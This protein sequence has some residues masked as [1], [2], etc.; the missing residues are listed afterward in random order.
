VVLDKST[1][2]YSLYL[3]GGDFT[4][5]TLVTEL[6]P[7]STSAFDFRGG[8][9]LS[10]TETLKVYLR[11]GASANHQAPLYFDDI[12]LAAGQNLT[13]PVTPVHVPIIAT[14][15][16]GS[17]TRTTAE[18]SVNDVTSDGN[19]AITERGVVFSTSANPTIADTKVV[20]SGTTGTFNAS[21]TGLVSGTPYHVRAFATNAIGT[22]YGSGITFT[23]NAAPVFSGMTVS[24]QP[25]TS[26]P[27]IESKIL[28]RITDGDG[29]PAA[30]TSVAA[31][32]TEG[33]TLSRSGGIIT[34]TPA[35]A[36]SGP[37]SF[38]VSVDD[39]FG[40]VNVT[41]QVTVAADP[42]FTSPAN[43][44]RLT[45]L[46]GGAKR[47]AFNGIPGRTYAIQRSTTLDPG[48]WTQIAAVTAASDS[49][50]SYEDPTPPQPAAFYRVA[51][52]AQ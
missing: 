22:A 40:A 23:A 24:T 26:V 30:I 25:A 11:S 8:G 1:A 27:I 9:N 18:I 20:V 51:Y 44:P 50:V 49:T 10:D 5:Q 39:G 38:T 37:D 41:I 2:K 43:A 34:Y 16:S 29:G 13:P 28:A 6:D 52:P 3:Q 32:S 46:A 7:N 48:S 31:T 33:G 19:S 45:D 21:L 15:T 14:G 47:I 35:L 36:F 12:Y 17:I 42:L 4:S